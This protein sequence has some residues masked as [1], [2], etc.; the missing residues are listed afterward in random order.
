M[1][2]LF[3][4][5]GGKFHITGGEKIATNNFTFLKS[6]IDSGKKWE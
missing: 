2:S 5:T 3:F 4:V 1:M 6:P